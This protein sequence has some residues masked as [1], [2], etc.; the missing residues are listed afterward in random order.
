MTNSTGLELLEAMK[1]GNRLLQKVC[2][3]AERLSSPR[4]T[5][6]AAGLGPAATG[7]RKICLADVRAA[8]A[9]PA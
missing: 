1:Q 8:P 9:A 6:C 5:T 4:A 2:K 3:L 7:D